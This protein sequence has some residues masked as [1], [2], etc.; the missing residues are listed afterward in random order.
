M[1]YDERV[2]QMLDDSKAPFL[3]PD[4][5]ATLHGINLMRTNGYAIRVAHKTASATG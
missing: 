2:V 5:E 3:R 1:I 4:L